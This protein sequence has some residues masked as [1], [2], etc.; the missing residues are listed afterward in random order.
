MSEKETCCGGN[1][2][3]LVVACSGASNVGQIANQ[4]MLEVAKAGVANA[5]CLAGIGSGQSGFVESAKAGD[6]IVVDGCPVGCSHK[7]LE[8]QGIEPFRYFVVTEFGIEK[9]HKVENLEPEV[10]TVLGQ[11]LSNI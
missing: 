5:F 1:Q 6:L 8:R 7:V 3:L 10:R 4:V 11:V 9:D 2:T